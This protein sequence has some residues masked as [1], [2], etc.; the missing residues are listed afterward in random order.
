MNPT[1]MKKLEYAI[2]MATLQL[3][4]YKV[5]A[6]LAPALLMAVT[7]IIGVLSNR[8]WQA[9][10][11]VLV[12]AVNYPRWKRT[13]ASTEAALHE[14]NSCLLTNR[15]ELSADAQKIY[16]SSLPSIRALWFGIIA[17]GIVTLACICNGAV[18]IQVAYDTVLDVPTLIVGLFLIGL[19]MLAAIPVFKWI[20]ML[21][22]ARKFKEFED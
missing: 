11:Y 2:D 10:L 15:L 8:W 18:I 19:G 3:K 21:P 14:F 13:I 17:L 4:E 5:L 9:I 6:F 1:E 7:V 16:E 22:R 20:L 12:L